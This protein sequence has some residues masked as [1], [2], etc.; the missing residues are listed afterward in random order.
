MSDGLKTKPA[1]TVVAL[2]RDV[3]PAASVGRQLLLRLRRNRMAGIGLVFLTLMMLMAIL[4][5]HLTPYQPQQQRL[6]WRLQPPSRDHWMGTDELGRDIFTRVAYGGRV[7]LV[8][9]VLGSSIGMLT[10]V[11]L[12]ATAGYLGGR[13]DNLVMRVIDIMMS[14]PGVLLAI[15]IVAVLGPGTHNLVVALSIW[16]TPTFARITRGCILALR[17]VEFAEAARAVGAGSARIL[18]FHLLMNSLSPI[19]VYMTLSVATSILVAAGLGFLGLGVQPPT[20]EWG[21]MVSTGRQYLRDAPH[22]ILFPGLAIFLTVLS[23]NFIG[24]A[25]RDALDPRLRV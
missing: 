25:L 16:F 18:F 9:G 13:F 15:L 23:I 11:T 8:I 21:I 14:F 24:D 1:P 22:V 19:I 2:E 20:A 3:R 12:G 4:A 17:D 5:P 6:L 7:S 10:G